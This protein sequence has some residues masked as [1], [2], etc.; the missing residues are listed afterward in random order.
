MEKTKLKHFKE[1]TD[2]YP[3]VEGDWTETDVR[4]LNWSKQ[5]D[6]PAKG[7]KCIKC[8]KL[9]HYAKHCR[10]T[11]KTGHIANEE[12]Y[13]ADEDEWTLDRKL[14][15]QQKINS[16]GIKSNNGQP[17]Y[18]ITLLVN[19]RRIKFIVNTGSA[20]TLIPKPKFNSITV[21]KPVTEH[22]RDVNDNKIK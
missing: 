14:S 10:S 1:P 6:C 5:Y 19:N 3:K 2:R 8:D 16:M 20:V 7:R 18:T 13:S 17:F 12:T 22:Y 9:G 15:N 11:R 4:A 21:I